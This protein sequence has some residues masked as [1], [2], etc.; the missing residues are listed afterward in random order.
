[1]LPSMQL[2][3]KHYLHAQAFASLSYGARMG[4]WIDALADSHVRSCQYHAER[5]PRVVTLS[6]N[7]HALI[8]PLGVHPIASH[9]SLLRTAHSLFTICA[10]VLHCARLHDR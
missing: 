1:M 8:V 7:D 10:H 4:A 6:C 5:V 2:N 9:S 3:R